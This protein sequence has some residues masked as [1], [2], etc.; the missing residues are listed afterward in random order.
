MVSLYSVRTEGVIDL[1][2]RTEHRGIWQCAVR[3]SGM[4]EFNNEPPF[5][6]LKEE[7]QVYVLEVCLII[8]YLTHNEI[9]EDIAEDL[10]VSADYCDSNQ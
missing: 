3:E 6:S 10:C 4:T 9:N 2:F 7:E 8:Y 5:H 1:A